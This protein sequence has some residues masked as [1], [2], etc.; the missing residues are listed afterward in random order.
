[1][2]KVNDNFCKLPGSYLFSEVARRL[3]AYSKANPDK[4]IIKM[5]IGDVTR[6]ICRASLEAMHRAVDDQSRRETFHGYGS[7]A[8]N[9]CAR[10]SATTT[11]A[12]SDSTSTS[13]RFSSAT[14]PRATPAI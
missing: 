14:E 5:G 2:F 10:P 1:M 3:A 12:V 4:T 7:R 13:T 8:M 6:P 9:S 11:T